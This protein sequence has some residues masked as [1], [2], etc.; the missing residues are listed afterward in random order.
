MADYHGVNQGIRWSWT[1]STSSNLTFT[2]S[3]PVRAESTEGKKHM[4]HHINRETLLQRVTG[5]RDDYRL[6][7]ASYKDLYAEEWNN[8]SERHIRGEIPQAEVKVKN[9]AG[10]IM[11]VFTDMSDVFDGQVEE[12]ELDSRHDVIL[13]HEEYLA[14]VNGVGTNLKVIQDGIKELEELP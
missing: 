7:L 14:Y 13:T 10:G 11:T 5:N 9:K 12:L 3:Q 1:A 8:L 2:I 6:A 4:E